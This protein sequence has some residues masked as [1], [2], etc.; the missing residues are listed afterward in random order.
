MIRSSA[1]ADL[2]QQPLHLSELRRRKKSICTYFIFKSRYSQPRSV[3][4]TLYCIYFYVRVNIN[5]EIVSESSNTERNPV[6]SQRTA[7]LIE[8]NH[9]L[10][11]D[12]APICHPSPR[13]AS[14]HVWILDSA[15]SYVFLFSFVCLFF[16]GHHTLPPIALWPDMQLAATVAI[17]SL[18]SYRARVPFGSVSRPVKPI[19]K[20]TRGNVFFHPLC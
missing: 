14:G 1:A 5:T 9:R 16:N 3:C 13:R 8:Y 4:V 12:T 7:A 17:W 11:V 6:L 20:S 2:T 15:I 18:A 19:A 10:C